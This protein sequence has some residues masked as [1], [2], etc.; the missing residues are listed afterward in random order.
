MSTQVVRGTPAFRL[1]R[2]PRK[3]ALLAHVL[4]SVGWFGMAIMV[5]AAGVAAAATGDATLPAFLYRAMA[6]AVWLTVPMGVLALATGVLLGVGTKWGLVAHWWVVAKIVINA[7][8]LVTDPL[9]VSRAANRAL[10]SGH[11]P[12]PLY[13]STIAHCVM[14]AVA[15]TLSVVKPGGRTLWRR[16]ST[17]ASPREMAIAGSR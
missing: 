10:D 14:L 13:G 1:S 12:T 6:D 4:T 9:V 2:T 16:T 15:T 7:A 11:A 3:I 17:A 8:V 5:A